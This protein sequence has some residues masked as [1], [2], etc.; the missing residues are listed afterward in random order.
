MGI[1]SWQFF[2]HI[3][4]FLYLPEKKLHYLLP[5]NFLPDDY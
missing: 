3:I 2:H 1:L 5:S 4:S